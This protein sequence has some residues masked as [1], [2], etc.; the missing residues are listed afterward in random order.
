MR[1]SSKEGYTHESSRA[2]RGR[3][4]GG[5]RRFTGKNGL[6]EDLTV[7]GLGRKDLES[8][9]LEVGSEGEGKGEVLSKTQ[10]LRGRRRH[11]S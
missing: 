8:E 10:Q 4:K 9:V 3:K 5:Q 11:G 7:I 1:W 6:E 2:E